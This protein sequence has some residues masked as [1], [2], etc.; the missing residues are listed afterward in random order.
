MTREN[1]IAIFSPSSKP[2]TED[3]KK[4]ITNLSNLGF[5]IETSPYLEDERDFTE[6]SDY[7]RLMD[8][9]WAFLKSNSTILMP[10]RGGYGLSRILDK[11]SFLNFYQIQKTIF[12][13]SDFTFVLNYLATFQNLRVFHGPM[14]AK[15][16][17]RLFEKNIDYFMKA[18]NG[19][20]FEI[21]WEGEGWGEDKEVFVFG[22]NLTCFVHLIGTSYF[23][24]LENALLFIEEINEDEYRVDRMLHYLKHTGILSK[25]AGVIVGYSDIGYDVYLRFFRRY[26]IPF[27]VGVPAGHGELNLPIPF[28]RMVKV[29]FNACKLEVKEF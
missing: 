22:G 27:S 24:P 15:N 17:S 9:H 8:F 7:K 16:F 19:K 26:T 10:S 20:S 28:G 23:P 14:A 1:S 4:A 29:S 13:Y 11:I 2:D 5:R 12:G 18:V 21:Q 6:D 25:V 3:L